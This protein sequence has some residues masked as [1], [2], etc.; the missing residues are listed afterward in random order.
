MKVRLILLVALHILISV[1]LFSQNSPKSVN[2]LYKELVSGDLE[3][4]SES[5]EKPKLFSNANDLLKK[6]KKNGDNLQMCIAHLA[7]SELYLITFRTTKN[8][9]YH[10]AEAIKL[11]KSISNI[12]IDFLINYQL[13]N[14]SFENGEV[15]KAE[16]FT[17]ISLDFLNNNNISDEKNRENYGWC[18][19]QLGTINHSLGRV[20]DA[21]D[22][23]KKSVQYFDKFEQTNSYYNLAGI[24][25]ESGDY[26][27]AL[28]YIKL[29]LHGARETGQHDLEI[30]IY[31]NIGAHWLKNDQLDSAELY[32]NKALKNSLDLHIHSDLPYNY[33]LLSQLQEKKGDYRLALEYSTKGKNLND[34]ILKSKV[35]ENFNTLEAIHEKSIVEKELI[36]R[37]KD[38]I[39]S[40]KSVQVQNLWLITTL[41][42]LL[43][44][45]AATFFIVK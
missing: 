42:L 19:N 31:N 26:Q 37:E 44:I 11:S 45:M 20:D 7:L 39:I 38:L 32:L 15:Q 29:T 30:L 9:S 12:Q 34:S 5:L 6:S 14:I 13:A 16:K 22:F 4:Q 18:F 1:N 36:R 3:Q 43:S 23:L 33:D 28:H 2:Q 41:A 17:L 25:L 24:M 27:D 21:I 8:S 40:E 35:A 10:L